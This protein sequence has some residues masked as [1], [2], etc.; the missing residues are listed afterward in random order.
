M[1]KSGTAKF[2]DGGLKLGT[3]LNAGKGH[4][5]TFGIGYEQ[6]A[7]QASNAFVSP[8]VNNDFVL[9]LKLEKVFSTELGY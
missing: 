5:I 7:P 6:R 2:L 1:G 3:T 9:D 8:E 4:A